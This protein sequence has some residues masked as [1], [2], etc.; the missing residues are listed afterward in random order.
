MAALCGRVR[1]GLAFSV[2]AVGALLAATTGVVGATVVTM[3]VIALP[4]M[5]KHG[6]SPSLATGTIAASGTPLA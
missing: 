5:L 6:Y 1:G 3:G 4:A 2:I